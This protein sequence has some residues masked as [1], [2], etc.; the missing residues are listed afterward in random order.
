M[1]EQ[2]AQVWN[3]GDVTYKEDF[4]GK[5]IEIE[6]KTFIVME[7]QEA[8]EFMAKYLSPQKDGAGNYVNSKPLRKVILPLNSTKGEGKGM[9]AGWCAICNRDFGSKGFLTV[10]FKKEHSNLVPV[11]EKNDDSS[12]TGNTDKK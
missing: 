12:S 6:P 3:E 5:L 10:H 7:R 9:P 11:E 1:E 2:Y 8:S 4:K